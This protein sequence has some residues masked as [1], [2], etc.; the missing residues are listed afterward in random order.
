MCPSFEHVPPP[1]KH[2]AQDESPPHAVTSE[3]QFCSAH[4]S[5]G[6]LPLMYCWQLQL[7]PPPPPPPTPNPPMLPLLPA[8]PPEH[9]EP[10]LFDELQPTNPATSDATRQPAIQ[11]MTMTISPSAKRPLLAAA[12]HAIHKAVVG[13]RGRL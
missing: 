1:L 12:V 6:L 3:Q 2:A 7:P 11:R 4:I 10:P 9:D 8:L 13:A 5:H